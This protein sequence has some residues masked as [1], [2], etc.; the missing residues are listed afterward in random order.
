MN[1]RSI[2]I[3][4]L[5]LLTAF[6]S[7]KKE[8]YSFGEL[9]APTN[10]ALAAVVAGVDVANPNG[11]GSGNVAI[12]VSATNALSYN[13]D[14]GDGT[15]QAVPSGVITHKY[16]TPGT[17]SY[18]ITVNAVG[19]G[20]AIST[21][22]KLITV[23][24]AFE[25]PADMMLAITNGS[26]RKWVTDNDAVGHFGVGPADAFNS[27]WYAAPPNTREACA[28]DD[29][30]TFKKEPLD[31]ISMTI[32]NKGTSFSIGA[33]TG[34]YGFSGGDGCYAIN[35][36]GTR[37]LSFLA[38]TSTSTPAQSTRIQFVVPGNGIINFGTGGLAYEIL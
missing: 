14:F 30:I 37:M 34:V 18:T 19:T 7:C 5:A 4:A 26:S 13:I 11:N 1:I 27:I 23:F 29:E 6:S 9:K 38:A 35:T 32:D 17:T 8:E 28:Y 15:T 22:S 12:T 33:A 21:I 10:L 24:V 3:I 36:G 20:G 25:I 2:T 16:T 31:R